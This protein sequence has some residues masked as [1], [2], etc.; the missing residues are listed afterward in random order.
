MEPLYLHQLLCTRVE[1]AA[2]VAFLLGGKSVFSQLV[3]DVS[4]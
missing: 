2:V 1:A 3:N 4:P